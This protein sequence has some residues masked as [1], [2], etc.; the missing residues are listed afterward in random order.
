MF[1]VES[2][3]FTSLQ[4]SEFTSVQNPEFKVQSSLQFIVQCSELRVESSLKLRV[5]LSSE[6]RIQVSSEFRVHF[7]LS[8]SECIWMG[9]KNGS[10]WIQIG[11]NGS[12]YVQICP[13][14]SEWVW[15]SFEGSELV[16]KVQ[17][18]E[19]RVQLNS[20]PPCHPAPLLPSHPIND[21]VPQSLSL[22]TTSRVPSVSEGE[23]GV[24]M[25]GGED[26]FFL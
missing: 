18:L 19:V 25:G 22:V 1:S 20:L 6:F 26:V 3:E 2:C 23:G 4:S 10:E 15:M 7:S 21:H 12:K 24:Q 11:Q 5:H 14:G 13:N 9:Q 16:W 8:G 17:R